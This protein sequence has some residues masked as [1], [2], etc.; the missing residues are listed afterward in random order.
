MDAS[1]WL[2]L[3]RGPPGL[4]GPFLQER[5][6]VYRGLSYTS[7]LVMLI[8]GEKTVLQKHRQIH[9]VPVD[10]ST[11]LAECALHLQHDMKKVKGGP[12]PG[13]LTLHPVDMN[14][15]AS[16]TDVAHRLYSMTIAPLSTAIVFFEKEFGGIA[17]IIHFLAR[18]VWG[19]MGQTSRY[20]PC[21]V[22]VWEKEITDLPQDL[23]SRMTAEILAVCNPTR[24][25]TAKDAE[26]IW[27]GIFS[28]F[29]QLRSQAKPDWAVIC[30]KAI[31]AARGAACPSFSATCLIR[32]LR[33]GCTQFSL[34][35]VRIFNIIRASRTEQLRDQLP[36]QIQ[37]LFKHVMDDAR[38]LVPASLLAASA[39]AI[40]SYSV[41]LVAGKFPCFLRPTY[42]FS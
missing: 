36:L 29:A 10:W 19:L 3:Y 15:L 22:I 17:A 13:N 8:R 31:V 18:W 37:I 30:R 14:R 1:C 5:S 9:L 35:A 28:S 23:E 11:A 33:A 2:D 25:L 26:V 39:L 42:V 12:Q 32:L 21:V 7:R 20:R 38:I 34:T 24:E 27:R 6:D 40:D 16:P 41:S 4:E